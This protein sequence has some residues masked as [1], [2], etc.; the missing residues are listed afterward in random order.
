MDHQ[1]NAK[2]GL[3]DAQLAI[4][5]TVY[6][7]EA[8]KG[9]VV[10]ISGGAGGIGR[11][12]AWLFARLGAHVVIV[13]RN[14]A[15]LDALVAD[16]TG[17]DLKA[18]AYVTDIREPE[19]VGRPVRHGLDRAWPRRQ[20]HQQCRRTVSA[21]RDRFFDKRLERGHRHQSERHL[22][23]R[24]HEAG[25]EK[26][27]SMEPEVCWWIPRLRR[28]ERGATSWQHGGRRLRW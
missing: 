22:D 10:V 4:H 7:A 9:Q 19:A 13:G 23:D 26:P 11:A 28:A 17:R 27:A 14:Q 18:S 15:K 25:I 21:S 16:L 2:P 20:S 1:A 5:P 24:F 8:F 3:T 6:A 12:I